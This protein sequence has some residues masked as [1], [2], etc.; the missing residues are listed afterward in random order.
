MNHGEWRVFLRFFTGD[1]FRHHLLNRG[2]LGGLSDKP[3]EQ[4]TPTT[5]FLHAEG[6]GQFGPQRFPQGFLVVF[7]RL[8][9]ENV[10]CSHFTAHECIAHPFTAERVDQGCRIANEID[11]FAGRTSR[12]VAG[13]FPR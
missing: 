11:A 1:H 2:F 7:G 6:I 12:L 13:F 5:H 3:V 9:F 10:L 4:P 8:S